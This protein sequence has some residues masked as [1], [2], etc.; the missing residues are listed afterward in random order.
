M[1][2][3]PLPEYFDLHRFA[4]RGA[5]VRG[6]IANGKMRRLVAGLAS[7][8]GE[9]EA[10]MRF[11]LDAVRRPV[12]S[13][14]VRTKVELQCQ[15]CMELFMQPID[16]EFQLVRVRSETEAERLPEEFE[17][18]LTEQDQIRTAEL[19]ED[20]L[21]L[22]LPVVAMHVEEDGCQVQVGGQP[23]AGEAVEERKP[24]PFAALSAL[25]RKKD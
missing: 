16:V 18:L 3:T 12:I 13:G 21:I 24:N 15:R 17:P 2:G 5:V 1:P 14:S 7:D 8:R 19:L 6:S 11:S 22:A 25:N 9:A 23:A 4:E 20:E 10:E